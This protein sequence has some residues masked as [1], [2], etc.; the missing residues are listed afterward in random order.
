[1]GVEVRARAAEGA[2]LEE[3]VVTGSRIKRVDIEGPSPISVISREDI[4]ASGEISEKIGLGTLGRRHRADD[5][6]DAAELTVVD[7]DVA[8]RRSGAREHTNQLLQ[9]PHLLDL[10]E[11]IEEVFQV[12]RRVEELRSRSLGLLLVVHRFVLLDQ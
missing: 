11:L 1:M 10:L 5:G 3:I 7:L 12:E 9:W 8:K 4:D 2:V 6:L